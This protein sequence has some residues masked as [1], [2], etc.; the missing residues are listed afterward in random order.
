[1]KVYLQ[2]GAKK[3]EIIGPHDGYLKI[4]IKAPAVEGKANL[5]LIY[6]LSK[7]FKLRQNQIQIDKG[8]LSRKK[9]VLFEEVL[10][11]D[12]QKILSTLI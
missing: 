6:F 4:K 8:E 7:L 2:P 12:I 11:E 10:Y 1:L 3:S 5:E 9:N